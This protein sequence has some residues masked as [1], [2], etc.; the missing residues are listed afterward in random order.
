M[1]STTLDTN[2]TPRLYSIYQLDI[3][4]EAPSSKPGQGSVLLKITSAIGDSPTD[5]QS[6]VEA[7]HTLAR[8]LSCNEAKNIE[9]DSIASIKSKDQAQLP[10]GTS[11]LENQS[12]SSNCDDEGPPKDEGFAWVVAICALLAVFCTW[13]SNAGYGVFLSFYISSDTFAGA[14]QYDYALIG[15]MIICF[16]QLLAPVCALCYR[17]FGPFYTSYFGIV[18]QTIG[19]LLASFATKK[20]HLYCTQGLLV[21]VSFLFVYLPG[22]LMIST[23]FE[24]K[25]ATAMGLAFSGVGLGG[26]FFSLVIRKIISETGNQRWALRMSAFAAGFVALIACSIMKPRNYKP[27]P[28][29]FTLRKEF[30]YTNAK[31]IFSASVF[32]DYALVLLGIWFGICTIGYMLVLFTISSYGIL[33]G[34]SAFQ[35]SVLTAVLNAGQVFGRPF[36]GLVGDKLGRFNFAIVNCLILT[37]LILAFWIKATSFGALLAFSILI[38]STI[39]VGSLFCQSLAS[40]ILQNMEKLPAAWSGLNMI[41]LLFSIGTEVFAFA[42]K[43]DRVANPYLHTQIFVGVCFFFSAILLFVMREKVVRKRFVASLDRDRKLHF[44]K[45]S[46]TS[47]LNEVSQ[48]EVFELVEIQMRIDKYEFLAHDSSVRSFF[49]RML[50]P[51]KV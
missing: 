38:G 33:V 19:Y 7:E 28:F 2:A 20:W 5:Y 29:N 44:D 49:A 40:D 35:G 23:W 36:C 12:E 1:D 26:V 25:K 16:A 32:K 14:T 51:M 27:L 39:G 31:S 22:T 45:S 34:L 11:D 17:I 50:Y 43:K 48:V 21:G 9:K 3:K 24:K 47:T 37:V 15:G 8:R 42:L 6:R 4:T 30:I 10:K 41:V 18:L 46:L 13:G